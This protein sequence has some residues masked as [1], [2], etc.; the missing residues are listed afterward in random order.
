MLLELQFCATRLLVLIVKMAVESDSEV[1]GT[2]GKDK[3]LI[4]VRPVCIN[5]TLR[6]NVV[7][8]ETESVLRILSVCCSLR[9][10]ACKAHAPHYI[11][12]CG[13]TGCVIFFHIIS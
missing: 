8:L 10:P 7:A 11:V 1:R 13:L 9:Y 6:V 4:S 2:E 3:F 12:V 5:V